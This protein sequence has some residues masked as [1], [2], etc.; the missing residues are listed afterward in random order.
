MRRRDFE[1]MQQARAIGYLTGCAI[2]GST[3][4]IEVHHWGERG[5]GQKC[6]DLEV[7]PLCRACHHRLHSVGVTERDKRKIQEWVERYGQV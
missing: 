7:V 3:L 6:S 1:A 2:C 5:L 4:H